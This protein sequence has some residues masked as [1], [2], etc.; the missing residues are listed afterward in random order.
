MHPFHPVPSIRGGDTFNVLPGDNYVVSVR[1][2]IRRILERACE[3][4]CR[5]YALYER[6][7]SVGFFL[8]MYLLAEFAVKLWISFTPGSHR[9]QQ[10]LSFSTYT[11]GILTLDFL[12]PL[13]LRVPPEVAHLD[14]FSSEYIHILNLM[15][16]LNIVSWQS[17]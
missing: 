1:L 7:K 4:L 11:H 14:A 3:R 17:A 9:E 5:V 2:F 15:S 16:M 12:L 8:A 6:S 13:A 10:N